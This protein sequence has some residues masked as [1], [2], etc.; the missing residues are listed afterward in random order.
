MMTK[1]TK[2]VPPRAIVGTTMITCSKFQQNL[3]VIITLNNFSR[4]TNT[5][6]NFSRIAQRCRLFPWQPIKLNENFRVRM[7]V[8]LRSALNYFKIDLNSTYRKLNEFSVEVPES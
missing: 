7:V 8:F 3:N 6:A 4:I 5:V 2:I 1:N